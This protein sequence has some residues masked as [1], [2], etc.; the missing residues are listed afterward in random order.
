MDLLLIDF[1][2]IVTWR[3]V[4]I[5]EYFFCLSIFIIMILLNLKLATETIKYLTNTKQ[6]LK[7]R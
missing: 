7:F 1:K 6:E 5:K 2:C 3:F 4:G